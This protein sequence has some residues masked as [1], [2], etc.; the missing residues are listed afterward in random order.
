M[1]PYFYVI[2]HL[3]TGKYYAGSRTAKDAH[4][5]EFLVVGGYTTSSKIINLLIEEEGLQSF[6]VRRLQTFTDAQSAFDY[7]TRF[8]R[9][10][11]A[12]ANPRFFNSHNNK[13]HNAGSEGYKNAMLKQYGVEHPM[14]DERIKQK[15]QRTNAEKYGSTCPLRNSV[16]S[17][18]AKQTMVS[19]YGVEHFSHSPLFAGRVTATMRKRLGVDW[20]MQSPAVR[21]K[22]KNAV[23]IRYGVANVAQSPVVKSKM[24][25]T[26]LE[27]YGAEHNSK[28][29]H[30]CP[31]CG[32]V[33]NL[34]WLSRHIE[35]CDHLRQSIAHELHQ[36]SSYSE[37]ARDRIL[38]ASRQQTQYQ[39]LCQCRR[40]KTRLSSET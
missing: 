39:V 24:R 11:N 1:I 35:Q 4:P 25:A 18:K 12:Q 22:S 5:S 34:N 6:A 26:S 29:N 17:E 28:T 14:H 31:A 33:C 7:E 19:K 30:T 38:S 40:C 9:K 23:M 37:L 36:E 8:L 16:V 3:A 27:R 13:L 10:V 2:Q 20:A 15:Q 32:H 21:Q